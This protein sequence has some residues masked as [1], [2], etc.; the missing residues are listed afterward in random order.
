MTDM[1][2][3]AMHMAPGVTSITPSG[4]AFAALR[5]DRHV[6]TWGDPSFGGYS[7]GVQKDGL[8]PGDFR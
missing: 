3:L 4:S 2:W 7:N 8:L 6:V 1:H 5:S